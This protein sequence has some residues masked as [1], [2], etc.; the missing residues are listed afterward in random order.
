MTHPT[1][2]TGKLHA[3]AY[4]AMAHEP[5]NPRV[6]R[7]YDALGAVIA[8]Q[9]NGLRA[10]GF[11]FYARPSDPYTSSA[12][13]LEDCD[14]EDYTGAPGSLRVFCDGGATLPFDHPMQAAP[15]AYGALE[16][17]SL[18]FRTLNDVFR[19]VHDVMGHYAAHRAGEVASFGPIG[20][21][22]AWVAHW[23][24]L[25][26]EAYLALWCETR[27]QNAY[28]NF[29]GNHAELPIAERPYVDQRAGIPRL[30]GVALS[31]FIVPET[32]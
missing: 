14:P 32:A 5:E 21:Y 18:G 7:S 28:T 27:G 17:E 8:A 16:A 20:E 6:K 23:R 1:E 3:D 29:Y 9:W 13:M 15:T 11:A 2:R 26:S 24:T 22:N 19:G 30:P 12:S 31:R 25:P 10:A 4:A